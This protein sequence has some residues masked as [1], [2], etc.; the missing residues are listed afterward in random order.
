MTVVLPA[1]SPPVIRISDRCTS[2]L[3]PSVLV[4]ADESS[5]K[6][7][8][9]KRSSQRHP[10]KRSFSVGLDP[11]PGAKPTLPSRSGVPERDALAKRAARELETG[12]YP[13]VRDLPVSHRCPASGDVIGDRSRDVVRP[14]W[15]SAPWVRDRLAV[16]RPAVDADA[17]VPD[18]PNAAGVGDVGGWV[19]LDREQVGSAAGCDCATVE[20][21][22]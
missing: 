4:I 10:R 1:P 17:L 7:R 16:H 22:E 9:V 6:W 8:T 18:L 21:F 12:W 2:I 11:R 3:L 14:V 20:E 13:F 5:Q 15:R 19:A